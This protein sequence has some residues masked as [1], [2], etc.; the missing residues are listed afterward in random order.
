M[1]KVFSLKDNLEKLCREEATR[2]LVTSGSQSNERLLGRGDIC[3]S[4]TAQPDDRRLTL[5][6]MPGGGGPWIS[7][8]VLA[9]GDRPSEFDG[10]LVVRET[11]YFAEPFAPGPS[12]ARWTER[13]A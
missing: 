6:R 13:V 7:E 9:C 2:R 1:S 10:G 8:L 4:R 11:Q 5:R 3:A 12:R